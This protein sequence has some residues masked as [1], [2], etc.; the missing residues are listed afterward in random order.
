MDAEAKIEQLQKSEGSVSSPDGNDLDIFIPE[1]QVLK[2]GGR[3]Y[4]IRPLKLKEMRLLVK[5]AKLKS[6]VGTDE[7]LD[8]VI[9]I[10]SQLLKEP[11]K[12]FINEHMDIPALG[13][14]FQKINLVNYGKTSLP[15]G[16][17]SG[18][19]RLEKV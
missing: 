3:G 19:E 16:V 10:V 15:K 7:Q 9:D 4:K 5:L 2:F 17:Q 8:Q 12:E 13:E 1:P 14:L 18:N 11:D 6:V